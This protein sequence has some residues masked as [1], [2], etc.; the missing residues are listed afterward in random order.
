MYM[1]EFGE[2]GTMDGLGVLEADDYTNLGGGMDRLSRH[3]ERHGVVWVMGDGHSDMDDDD[4][5]DMYDGED[6]EI[7]GEIGFSD[8]DEGQFD[9]DVLD[10]EAGEGFHDAV[11]MP[12]AWDNPPR[13]ASGRVTSLPGLGPHSKTTTPL[14]MPGQ[15]GA[16]SAP[17]GQQQP[18]KENADRNVDANVNVNVNLRALESDVL[19][20]RV[21]EK[22]KEL[23]QARK[24][25]EK[26]EKLWTK[27]SKDIGRW[28]EGL[29]KG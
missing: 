7:D 19:Q 17:T 10:D 23:E 27:K 2:V 22:Q 12:G 21:V 20:K 11:N 26:I 14:R 9:E 18:P 16:P 4:G 13:S 5:F 6:G 3:G 8:D 15:V 1:E 29:V 24:E 28:R 25:M